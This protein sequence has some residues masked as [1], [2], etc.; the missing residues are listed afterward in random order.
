MFP[1]IL[2]EHLESEV[3]TNVEMNTIIAHVVMLWAQ[4]HPTSLSLT[5][6]PVCRSHENVMLV[7]IC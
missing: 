6:C 1:C 4:I 7:N 2:T 5:H 3:E